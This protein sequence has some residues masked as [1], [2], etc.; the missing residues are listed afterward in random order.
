MTL[1]TSVNSN[2]VG[3]IPKICLFAAFLTTCFVICP[4][5][6]AQ[7]WARNMFKEFSHDFGNVAKNSKVEHRFVIENPFN[8]DIT[9]ARAE[10]SCRCT[11]VSMTKK[12]L[13]SGEKAELIAKFNTSAFEGFRQ[14]TLT[15]RFAPPFVG[16]VQLHVKGN[17]RPDV[18]F[19][20]GSIDFSEVNRNAL[21]EKQVQVSHRGNPNWKIVDVRSTYGDV[22]VSLSRPYR[23]RGNSINYTM[24]VRLKESAAAGFQ[25]GELIVVTEEFGRRSEIPIKFSGKIV[26]DLQVSPEVL[27]INAVK[28]GD[29][30]KRKVVVK[31]TQPFRIL[32]V[33]C[34]NT[35]FKV[36]ADADAK[37]VHFVDISYSADQPPGRHECEMEFVTDLNEKTVGVMKAVIEISAEDGGH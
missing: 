24:T 16:E 36:E 12:T 6:T 37:K 10:T 23:G 33:T 13:K 9:I 32:D 14:A 19:Q 11:D 18:T 20:P 21:P 5:L 3:P 25:Q 2:R 8:E 7:E 1:D 31:G 17:I 15:V 35:S 28:S 4:E 27:T 26:S 30:V 29:E 22:G 34:T